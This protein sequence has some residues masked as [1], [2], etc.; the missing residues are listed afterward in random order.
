MQI[1]IERSFLKDIKKLKDEKTK[2]KLKEILIQLEELE[3]F[4][5]IPQMKKLKGFDFY[6]RIK[7]GDYRL[8]LSYHDQEITLI[9]FI[10]R[11]DI[12]KKFP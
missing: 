9:R 5:C 1:N 4:V 8:G 2:R 3:E 7:L 6:Y 11:K 10:H 12:Y